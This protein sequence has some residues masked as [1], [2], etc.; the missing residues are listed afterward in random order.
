MAWNPSPEVADCKTIA[1][2]WGKEQII[3]IGIDSEG[4]MKMATYG[5]TKELCKCA[6][7]LGTCAWDAIVARVISTQS[8]GGKV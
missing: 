6:E 4:T 1:Q 5:E 2:R 7:V 8:K 3:I